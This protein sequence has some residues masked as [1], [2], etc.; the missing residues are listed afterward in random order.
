MDA[1]GPAGPTTVAEAIDAIEAT[2]EFTLAYAAQGR[3]VEED[4]GGM[5]IRHFLRRAEGALSVIIGAT[6]QDIGAGTRADSSLTD[7]LEVVKR[8]AATA[9]AVVRFVLAQR[10]IASQMTD[11]LNASTHIRTLLT[12]LFL[13]DEALKLSGT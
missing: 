1:T 8:D 9:R 7:F 2:Y 11:N 12:D 5:G 3:R 6:S 13:L 4:D 10:S